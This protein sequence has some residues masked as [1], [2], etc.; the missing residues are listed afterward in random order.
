VLQIGEES[1][2]D[3]VGDVAVGFDDP[4]VKVVAES[5]GLGDLGCSAGETGFLAVP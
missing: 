2:F 3:F 4:V 5:A 1:G